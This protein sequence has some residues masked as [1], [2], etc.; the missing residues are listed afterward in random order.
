MR[1]FPIFSNRYEFTEQE[2]YTILRSTEAAD[3]ARQEKVY[4]F[5]YTDSVFEKSLRNYVR[6]RNINLNISQEEAY[7]EGKIETVITFDSHVKQDKYLPQENKSWRAYCLPIFN[8]KF[9]EALRRFYPLNKA[10]QAKAAIAHV[11]FERQQ[12]LA[13]IEDPV[14]QTVLHLFDQSDEL[15]SKIDWFQHEKYGKRRC[16]LFKLKHQEKLSYKEIVKRMKAQHIDT[17]E[18]VLRQENATMIKTFKAYFN[19]FFN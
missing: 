17:N 7:Q 10:L 6:R 19:N 15:F 14:Y 16:L 13:S 3:R 9:L 18:T 4:N 2:I 12:I 5:L 8:F 1:L 11:E